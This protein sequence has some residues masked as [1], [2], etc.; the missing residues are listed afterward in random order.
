MRALLMFLF[1]DGMNWPITCAW[2][3][4]VLSVSSVL[5]NEIVA[6]LCI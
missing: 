6:I 5:W 4:R 1:S 3:R 2:K